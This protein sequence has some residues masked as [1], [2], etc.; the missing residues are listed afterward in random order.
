VALKTNP[1]D[2]HKMSRHYVATLANGITIV[3]KLRLM[4]KHLAVAVSANIKLK[5][6]YDRHDLLNFS[7][8]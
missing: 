2:D 6:C 7:Q 4:S 3:Y 8:G 1:Q 5:E